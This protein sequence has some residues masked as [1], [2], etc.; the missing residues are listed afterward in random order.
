MVGARLVAREDD[1]P[2]EVG[3]REM[4]DPFLFAALGRR[5]ALLGGGLAD[6]TPVPLLWS[7]DDLESWRFERVWLT[8]A[9]PV[10]SGLAPAEIWECPQL[11][12]VEGPGCCSSRS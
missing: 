11:V 3:V 1:V 9:D 12:E 10:L 2:A 6:G 7:C 8:S 5:W 4:R